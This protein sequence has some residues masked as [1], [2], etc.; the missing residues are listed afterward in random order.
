VFAQVLKILAEPQYGDCVIAMNLSGRS[1]GTPGFCEY[2]QEQARAS[3][4]RPER[5]LF[6]VTETA[7]VTE[8]AKAESF[9]ATMKKEGYRF[10]LDDFGVGFSSF[11]YLKH[12]PVDQIKIDG[13]FIRHLDSNREDQIFVRAMVQVARE[14]GLE[15]VAEFVETQAALELLCDMGVDFVQG[16]HVARPGPTLTTPTVEL[17]RR[18]PAAAKLG[19]AAGR[20][21]GRSP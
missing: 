16:D 7:A 15:T 9:I 3:G 21:G 11:S 12:L 10:S 4:V 18:G 2:F 5:L 17:G 14:L 8:M 1:L 13:S 6:E 19:R 20:G